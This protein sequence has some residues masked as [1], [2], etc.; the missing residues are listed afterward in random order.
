MVSCSCLV[1]SNI[2]QKSVSENI[3]LNGELLLSGTLFLVAIQTSVIDNP[4][5][6]F[7]DLVYDLLI[8]N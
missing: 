5:V 4:D 2:E 6:T 3:T 1:P 7:L 8:V